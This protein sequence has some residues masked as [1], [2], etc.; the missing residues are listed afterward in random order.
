MHIW[1]IN[2]YANITYYDEGGRHYCFAKYL[3]GKG[4]EPVI[5]CSNAY[6]GIK[7]KYFKYVGRWTEKIQPSI[8]VPY[9]F[10]KNKTYSVNGVERIINMVDFYFN[11][12]KA[13]KEYAR[14]NGK[15]DIIYASSVHPLTLLAGIQLSKFFKV[16]CV[17]EVRDL[18]PESLI[19]YGIIGK[20]N[21]ITRALRL[22]EHYI[23]RKCDA[24]IFT[25]E[26]GYQYIIEQHWDSSVPKDKVYIINN[27][28]DLAEY[29]DNLENYSVKDVHL[30]D[31]HL[32]KVVYV[33][34]IRKVNNIGLLLDIAK[35][36]DNKSIVF[37]IWGSGD[38]LEDLKN[39]VVKE[40]IKNVFF[41]GRVEK[42]YIPYITSKSNLN[43]AHNGQSSIFK[44][45]I[46]FNKIFDYFAAGIPILCDFES[47]YN[48]VIT[49]GAGVEVQSTD[50]KN[51][52]KEIT[53]IAELDEKTKAR[54]SD[55]AITA[56]QY[57]NYE[58]LTEELISIFNN[59]KDE[60]L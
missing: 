49:F 55:G 32:F 13:A 41:K 52:A 22:L 31:K 14:L 35:N 45:G 40:D 11:I 43:I 29:R 9:V 6:H 10:V 27:G 46:S 7:K 18:W 34:S 58:K 37:L 12:K 53:R 2:H 30:D 23:Y 15:P 16:K 36:V 28:I 24:L 3:K 8:K 25:M 39:K 50:P 21:I 17:C 51:V 26:G 19:A 20:K 4:H 44:Y 42:K 47:S 57:Y 5:F 56:A 33:G 59:L 48:P 38:E 54:F 60:M 1:I